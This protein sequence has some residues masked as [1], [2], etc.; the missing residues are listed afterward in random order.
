MVRMHGDQHRLAESVRQGLTDMAPVEWQQLMGLVEQD[1]MRAAGSSPHRLQAWE[2]MPEVLRSVGERYSQQIEIEIQ[3]GI[4]ENSKRLIH[5]DG[6]SRASQ[7]KH[8][9]ESPVVAFGIDHADLISAL[10]EPLDD[11]PGDRR[12][13]APRRTGNQDVE[14]VRR[15][16]NRLSVQP[17]ANSHEVSFKPAVHP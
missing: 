12:L 16:G 6:M 10:D 9:G 11:P 4:L 2:K 7:G 17:H 5:G 8:L 14:T 1:P 15:N 3:L 13:A